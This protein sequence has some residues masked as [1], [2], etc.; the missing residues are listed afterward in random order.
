[1]PGCQ[2]Y[3]RRQ[4]NSCRTC[5]SH[6]SQQTQRSSLQ[7]EERKVSS[8][9]PFSAHTSSGTTPINWLFASRRASVGRAKPLVRRLVIAIK[10][11][12]CELR[13]TEVFELPQ[14]SRQR[15]CECIVLKVQTVQGRQKAQISWYFTP[16]L[17]AIEP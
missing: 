4:G 1:M 10:T 13:L 9:R 5:H 14:F 15:A 12:E 7:V 16:D 17:I 2:I 8:P 11:E 3:S 6:L